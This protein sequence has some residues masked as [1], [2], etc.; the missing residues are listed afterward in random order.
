MKL[1]DFDYHIPENQIAQHPLKERDASRLFVIKKQTE[2]FEHRLFRDII[3][4]LSRGDVLVLN[5]TKVIPVRLPGIKPSGGKAEITL[6]KEITANSWEALVKGVH[7][8]NVILEHGITARVSRLNGTLARV[9][10][11]MN[12]GVRDG[13]EADIKNFLNDVGVMPLP[14]YIKRGAVKADSKQYQ[15]VYAKNDGAVAAPTAGLHFTDKLINSIK[16]KGIN[17]QTITLHVGYG[18]FKPVA[19]EDIRGH[20]MDEEFYEI[21]ETTASAVN[22][23]KAEGRR[24]VA[25]GT[26]VTRALETSAHNDDGNNLPKSLFAKEGLEESPSLKK[27]G[28]GGFSEQT[29]CRITSGPCKTSI[30]IYPGYKFRIVDALV[31]NFHLPRST[32]MM[33]ASAFSG[34]ALLK[35]A[36]SAAQC[37]GYRFY[38]YGDAM[39]LL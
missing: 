22:A 38:S 35:K 2:K 28:K 18:T 20:Q 3:D 36:Y 31:T 16:G 9:D 10:F 4:Y 21:P 12:A 34:L 11:Y 15:T 26:T 27:G 19:V 8:G 33:L 32:P 14:V 29:Q 25:V 30:F 39:L 23:A 1:S 7:E 6:I 5:D 17:V 13:D 37:E 24:V